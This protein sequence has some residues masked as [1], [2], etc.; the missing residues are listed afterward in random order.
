MSG[1][2]RG[3]RSKGTGFAHS[4][5]AAGLHLALNGHRLIIECPLCAK[6]GQSNA[7][8]AFWAE[9]YDQIADQAVVSPGRLG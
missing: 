3:R 9:G 8:S 7:K 2:Y 4:I 6:S 5:E 1:S